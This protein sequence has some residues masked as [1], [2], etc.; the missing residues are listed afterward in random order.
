MSSF[1]G[2]ITR[3]LM[4]RRAVLGRKIL[5]LMRSLGM[6]P[7]VPGFSGTVPDG[8]AERNPA[9]PWCH[10]ATGW[11][12]TA[13]TGSTRAPRPTNRWPSPFYQHQTERF[14]LTG[15]YAVDIL[16]EGGNAGD[17][18]VAAA[19]Q[20]IESAMRAADPDALWVI[21]ARQNNPR[22]EIVEAVDKS[23]L[24]VLDI[25]SDNDP[26]RT[27]TNAFWSAPSTAVRVSR[28]G[29]HAASRMTRDLLLSRLRTAAGF[30]HPPRNVVVDGAVGHDASSAE[31]DGI[32]TLRTRRRRWLP[33]IAGPDCAAPDGG[34][35]S[36]G[37]SS[38]WSDG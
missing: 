13:R 24:L 2:P 11:A 38:N 27:D 34:G 1:G 28:I 29:P 15:A 7:V 35:E 20:G 32:R 10:R 33:R 19:G 17:V 16:H 31:G 14:G 26:R 3:D 6:T 12:S 8:F 9:R 22:R 5:D 4:E 36:A 21:Q 23:K 25:N 30:F 37:T 18:D